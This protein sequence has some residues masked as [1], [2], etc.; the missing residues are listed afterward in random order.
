MLHIKMFAALRAL[1]FV[2]V[3]FNSKNASNKFAPRYARCGFFEEKKGEERREK[4]EKR[5]ETREKR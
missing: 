4:R 1:W 2:I 3:D 5:E